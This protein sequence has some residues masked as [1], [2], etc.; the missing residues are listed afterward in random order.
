MLG[1]WLK[2]CPSSGSAGLPAEPLLQCRV[3]PRGALQLHGACLPLLP[4]QQD[5]QHLL[6]GPLQADH[7]HGGPGDD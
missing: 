1:A 5:L 6:A 2:A 4:R 3:L 7:R